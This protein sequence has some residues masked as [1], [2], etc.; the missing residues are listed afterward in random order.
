[1]K[2][3]D[4]S[5]EI[6]PKLPLWESIE[7]AGMVCYKMEAKIGENTAK[8]FV[9]R[10]LSRKHMSVLE[11]AP[12]VLAIQFQDQNENPLQM[13][14]ML[15]GLS[16]HWNV[17]AMHLDE[18]D[19]NVYLVSGP[20]RAFMEMEES[21]TKAW[22]HT[23]LNFHYPELFTKPAEV[24]RANMHIRFATQDMIDAIPDDDIRAKH[25]YETV[26][27]VTDR[28]V[29][30]ELVRH[31]PMQIL[32]ESQRYCAYHEGRFGREV[33]FINPYPS[34]DQYAPGSNAEFIWKTAMSNAEAFYMDLI[35]EGLS[36]QAARK[37]LPNSSKTEL[38]IM[39]NL[40]HWSHI[41]FLRTPKSADPTMQN[42][43][44]PL[45]HKFRLA[46]PGMF[47]ELKRMPRQ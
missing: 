24:P 2:V 13:L 3:M 36:A 6:V 16:K 15:K 43:M 44:N 32:Q 29:S 18:D 35:D 19:V 12:I 41:L 10:C 46:Y 8:P 26:L 20:A 40:E 11:M 38:Y 47:E 4:Q 34:F 7:R 1:M 27:F 33:T 25:T 45:W 42:L 14:T 22:L 39:T 31:R 30:H 21:G 37:T 23:W 17:S 5:A 28:S 9:L